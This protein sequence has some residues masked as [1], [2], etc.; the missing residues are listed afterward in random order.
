MSDPIAPT[1]TAPVAD[2]KPARGGPE[3]WR[4]TFSYA[5]NMGMT[6]AERADFERKREVRRAD[7]D[8]AR[9]ETNLNYI[10]N[11]SMLP[12]PSSPCAAAGR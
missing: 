12:C 8:C 5:T 6:P 11:Y 3:W 7:A 4:Q 2:A 1:E 9:C 10:L